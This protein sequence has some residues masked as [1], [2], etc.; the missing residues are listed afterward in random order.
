[1]SAKNRFNQP[2]TQASLVKGAHYA[3]VKSSG[4]YFSKTKQIGTICTID[5]YLSALQ[6]PNNR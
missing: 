6:Q 4:N 3:T 2:L 5:R 1:M